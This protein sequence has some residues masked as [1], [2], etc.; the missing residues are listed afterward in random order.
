MLARNLFNK[1]NINTTSIVSRQY[2]RFTHNKPEVSNPELIKQLEQLRTQQID[3]YNGIV[4]R[5]ESLQSDFTKKKIGRIARF[6]AKM[7]SVKI[8]PSTVDLILGVPLVAAL[9]AASVAFSTLC[10]FATISIADDILDEIREIKRKNC[11]G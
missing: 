5:I 1:T 3:F 2:A 10:A 9:T 11:G 4:W 6:V 8:T 7:K